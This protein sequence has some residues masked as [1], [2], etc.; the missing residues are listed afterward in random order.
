[1]SI[2]KRVVLRPKHKEKEMGDNIPSYEKIVSL[3]KGLPI[4]STGLEIIGSQIQ[5]Q[6]SM[7]GPFEQIEVT[8]TQITGMKFMAE[9]QKIDDNSIRRHQKII[10]FNT[11]TGLVLTHNLATKEWWRVEVLGDGSRKAIPVGVFFL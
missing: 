8:I 10:S 6:E 4:P 3:P 1:M 7:G 2:D 9:N 5:I 11:A